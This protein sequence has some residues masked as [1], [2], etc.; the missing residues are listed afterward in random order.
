MKPKMP[1]FR[2]A[3]ACAAACMVFSVPAS[4]AFDFGIS[5]QDGVWAA[6]GF[7][8]KW[9]GENWRMPTRASAGT[10]I[11]GNTAYFT[12]STSVI[13][14]DGASS[15]AYSFRFPYATPASPASVS[16]ANGTLAFNGFIS[17][18][19]ANRQFENMTLTAGA[20]AKLVNA[21][22]KNGVVLDHN[23]HLV[24]E[25][26]ATLTETATDQSGS[27]GRVGRSSESGVS[28]SLHIASGAKFT[29]GRHLLI[30]GSDSATSHPTGVVSVAGS[31]SL[32]DAQEIWLCYNNG[33][34]ASGGY[35]GL[36]VTDG[37]RVVSRSTFLM[38]TDYTT[39]DDIYRGVSE[40]LVSGEGSSLELMGALT[41]REYGTKRITVENGGRLSVAGRIRTY[42]DNDHLHALDVTVR[43]GGVLEFG[44]IMFSNH[45]ST[46]AYAGQ[47][48]CSFTVDGGTTRALASFTTATANGDGALHAVTVGENGWIFDTQNFDVIWKR[49]IN[50]GT[51]TFT[52]IGSGYFEFGYVPVFPGAIDVSEGMVGLAGSS[53]KFPGAIIVRSGAA[54]KKTVSFSSEQDATFTLEAGSTLQPYQ[55]S[56]SAAPTAIQAQS[57]AL[58]VT[59]TVTVRL[60]NAGTNT[61]TAGRHNVL[62]ILGDGAF[63]QSDLA[64][65][66]LAAGAPGRFLLSSDAKSIVLEIAGASVKVWTGAAGDGKFATGGNWLDGA[67]P[68]GGESIYFLAGGEIDNNLGALAVSSITFGPDIADIAVSGGGF[69][70]VGA[71]TNLSS[72]ASP[73]VNAPVRF[74]GAVTVK[75][76]ATGHDKRAQSHVVF[77]GGAYAG[78]GCGMTLP[79]AGSAAMFGHF[80]LDNAESSPFA[81]TVTGDNRAS[82]S[83][84]SS[85]VVPN[86]SNFEELY[87][88]RGA[89]VTAGVLRL[90]SSSAR[91]DRFS[92]QNWGEVVITGEVILTGSNNKISGY[93]DGVTG[94]VFKIE[95][96]V[97]SM[98]DNRMF[99]A[100]SPGNDT[101]A[102]EGTFF[103]GQGGLTFGDSCLKAVYSI[104][105]NNANSRQTIRPWHGFFAIERGA[106]GRTAAGEL[107]FMRN[108]TFCTDDESGAPGRIIVNGRLRGENTPAMTVS[109]SGV[110]ELN[111]SANNS[112]QPSVAVVDTATLKFGAADV[113]LTTGAVTFRTGTTLQLPAAGSGAVALGGSLS[114]DD[115]EGSDCVH[116]KLGEGTEAVGAGTYAL[117][118]ASAGAAT[119]E[120]F[121]LANPTAGGAAWRIG[122][123]AD[124]TAVL[125]VGDPAPDAAT[126]CVWT[127]AAGDGLFSTAANWAGGRRPQDVGATAVIR[128]DSAGGEIVN[129]VD[130]LSAASIAFGK[131][132]K[133]TA[134]SGKPV[135]GVATV[136]NKS[137][138]VVP[139]IACAL[140]FA[141]TYNV[142]F[143]SQTVNFSGGA[144]ATYP[145]PDVTGR[146]LASHTLLGDITFTE[147][148]TIPNQSSGKP[149][150]IASGANVRGKTL[151]AASY[152]NSNYH[153]RVE[154][155]GTGEFDTIAVG[156]KLVFLVLGRLVATGDVTLGGNADG[157]DFGYYNANSTGTVEAHGIYKN[158]TGVGKIYHYIQNMK[159]GAGGFGMYRKDYS[160]VFQKD[161]RLTATDDLAIHQPVSGDGPKDGDWGLNLNGKT[162]TIDTAGHT[163]TFDSWVS[164]T[165]AKI[166]KEGE[167]E[168]IMQSRKKQHTGGTIVNGGTLTVNHADGLSSG[169]VTVNNDA[170]LAIRSGCKSGTG[171][172]TLNGTSRLFLPDSAAGTATVGGA[173][174]LNA[175]TSLVVTNLSASV[176]PLAVKSISGSCVSLV[177]DGDAPLADGAYTVLSLSSGSL[178]AAVPQMFALAGTAVAGRN[179]SL[180]VSGGDLVLTVDGAGAP[181]MQVCVWTG[182][183]GDSNFSTAANWAGGVKPQAGDG[184]ALFFPDA[185]GALVNDIPGLTPATITFGAGIG[186]LSISG[187]TFAGVQSMENKS[188]AVTPVMNA[189]VEFSGNI[190]FSTTATINSSTDYSISGATI[191]FAG[192]ASGLKIAGGSKQ[193]VL[194]GVFER[195]DPSSGFASSSGDANRVAIL[196]GSTVTATAADCGNT[197]ELYIQPE[198]TLIVS[199]KTISA[200][201]R[202]WCWNMGK[203]VVLD[204][205]SFTYNGTQY[206]GYTGNAVSYG[207]SGQNLGSFWAKTIILDGTGA[208]CMYFCNDGSSA[209]YKGTAYDVYVGEG[210]MQFGASSKGTYGTQVNCVAR[211]HPWGSDFTIMAKPNGDY[212]S[213]AGDYFTN[214][215]TEFVTTDADGVTPRTITMDGIYTQNGSNAGRL[216][217]SG[218]GTYVQNGGSLAGKQKRT[219]AL[220]VKDTATLK[221]GNA[222]ALIGTGPVTMA[223]GT[224]LAVPVVAPGVDPV[225]LGSSFSVSGEG[226][227]KLVVG[228]G[229]ELAPGDYGLFAVSGG[230]AAGDA[231][232]FALQ[233][234]TAGD[235]E[236]Y[237]RN[238][239][240]L[241]LSVG[242]VK[243]V[244]TWT[245]AGDGVHFD[246]AGNWSP[247]FVPASGSDL[248]FPAVSGSLVNDLSGF[249]AKTMT[250]GAGSADTTISG[251]AISGVLAITNLSPSANIV[252]ANPV[253]YAP[254]AKME[255]WQAGGYHN[256]GVAFDEKGYVVFEGGVTGDELVNNTSGACNVFAGRWTRTSAAAY[257]YAKSQN[258]DYRQTIYPGSSLTVGSADYT[259]EL[260]IGEGGAFTAATI[261]VA[262]ASDQRFAVRNYGEYVVK[263]CLTVNGSTTKDVY[264]GYNQGNDVWK[265]EKVKLDQTSGYTPYFACFNAA[266]QGTFFIGSGG[267]EFGTG[268]SR[269]GIGKNAA[270]DSQTIRPWYSDFTIT[271]GVNNSPGDVYGFRDV[272]FNTDDESGVGRTITLDAVMLFNHTPTCT[273]SGSGTFLVNSTQHNTA[274]PP[275]TVKDSATLK[276]G[277][278]DAALSTASHTFHAGTTLA[279]PLVTAESGSIPV[280]LGSG[281]ALP[282]DGQVKLVIGDGSEIPAGHYRVLTVTDG[283]LPDG[284]AEKLALQNPTAG[285]AVLYSNESRTLRLAVGVAPDT[286][287]AKVW[288]GAAGDGKFSTAGN[289]LGGAMPSAGDDIFIDAASAGAIDNDMGELALNSITFKAT[290]APVTITGGAITGLAAITNLSTAANAVFEAPVAYAAGKTMELYQT[291]KY[292]S[293]TVSTM[294]AKGYVVFAG[295]VTGEELINNPSGIANIF[296]GRWTRT[297]AAD[298]LHAQANP[299]G[300][301]DFRQVVYP[302][303]SLTVGSAGYT[304]ELYIGEGGAFTAATVTVSLAADQRFSFHNLGE[305]VVTECLTVNGSTSKDV[306]TGYLAGN[307]VWKFEKVKLD[308]TSGWTPYFGCTQGASQGTFFI[309]SGGIEFGTGSSR[310]GIGKNAAGDSQ[311]IRPWY[312]DF[313][314]THGVNNSPGDVYGFR[315]VVF[316][317]DD[318]S[319]VGRTITLDAVMLFNYT[320]TC[321]IS[322]SGTF[323]VNSTQQNTAQPPVAV[324]DSATLKF[325]S[326]A[327]ALSTAAHTFHAGTTLAVPQVATDATPVSL[328][329]SFAVAGEGKVKVAIGDGSALADGDYPVAVVT[330][331][332]DSK[333]YA[334]LELANETRGP[335]EFYSIDGK[336]LR[337]AVGENAYS[338]PCVWTGAAG[339]GKFSTRGNWIAGKVPANGASI[340]F[341]SPVSDFACND[342]GDLEI[343]SI[344]FAA[345]SA[346][347]GVDSA[348]G[349]KFTGLLAVTNASTAFQ[350]VYPQTVFAGEYRAV[351][352][353]QVRF[354]GGVT[355]TCPANGI[356]TSS[357][358]DI[359][360]TMYG[361]FTFTEDWVVTDIG[362]YDKPWILAGAGTEVRGKALTGTQTSRQRILSVNEGASAYFTV[363][364]NGWSIGDIDVNGYVEVEGE[365]VVKTYS[366]DSGWSNFGRSGNK[367]TVKAERFVKIANSYVKSNIPVI[368]VGKGG[369]GCIVQDWRWQF[370]VNTTVKAGDDFE[371]L[372]VLNESD[373]GIRMSKNITLTIDVPE[374]KTVRLGCGV[375]S[376][377]GGAIKKTGAGTLVMTDTAGGTGGYKKTYAGGTAVAEGVVRFEAGSF[378]TGAV[379][380]KDGATLSLPVPGEAAVPGAVTAEGGATL[381]FLL[382]TSG[383]AVLKTS[384]LTVSG[385]TEGKTVAVKFAEGSSLTPGRAYTLT[386]GANL[387]PAADANALFSCPDGGDGRLSIDANGELVYTAPEYFFIRIAT[388]TV[389]VPAAWVAANGPEGCSDIAEI[390]ANGMPVWQNYCLGLDPADPASLV[391]CEAAVSQP[392]DGSGRF[393]IVAKNMN[394]PEED[395]GATVTAYLDKSL[396]GVNWS[397]DGEPETVSGTPRTVTFLRSLDA[398]ETR[399]FFRIRVVVQ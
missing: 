280:V 344:T 113:T 153:L 263:E 166:V 106:A 228:D 83:D 102:S 131:G 200:N 199:N 52:K 219:A 198:A 161:S 196:S 202:A 155:G 33:S 107:Y 31:G 241:R 176:K 250:F 342:I 64:K 323:L 284:Y 56:A 62:T 5:G 251:N 379:T 237:V 170:T 287:G 156:G 292:H 85:L 277:S 158:V 399:C 139:E 179:A 147:N 396:D 95:K 253:E 298:Y 316:N 304:K 193:N 328:G 388:G 274:Q 269:L 24:L 340:V 398:L 229:A 244:C 370:D 397:P 191:D 88:G 374:G 281:I 252:F 105:A 48:Y 296:A 249:A 260:Y 126:D 255:I 356:R 30:G 190:Q 319:G 299:S 69:T 386:S 142:E 346:S 53:A 210:G 148:W 177:V 312:S 35:G 55:S 321:T 141:G 61:A 362:N 339:D 309:G 285:A 146:S 58:P 393:A 197:F 12:N 49:T 345:G 72:S 389:K 194:K 264:T 291:A 232:A 57:F 293:A 211:F 187:E 324:K 213:Y 336:T 337:V 372:G 384:G 322:G 303:S 369:L 270:G 144:T 98:S 165:A 109:G 335:V 265:F 353:G 338:G 135:S 110:F 283:A 273:I 186:Q 221:F 307:D 247:A 25:N 387:D 266:S 225:A 9:T 357:S 227:V 27:K 180:S 278:V 290:T 201:Q 390:C 89:A 224:T 349:F 84:G 354:P 91:V 174:A 157:R 282:E 151:A 243:Q 60:G 254:G 38:G 145:D 385:G 311:T 149:F 76:N 234:A 37:A 132:V 118:T 112:A 108:V 125:Y 218:S 4:G 189:R 306:Y 67:A 275:V 205:Y 42:A 206:L 367:G 40:V 330:G 359:A 258:G 87:I 257:A 262:L 22:A 121:R 377:T 175:G 203:F 230:V 261:T 358:D 23:S 332:I 226:K 65:F 314:I 364:T 347:M 318:E 124:G 212:S 19:G 39:P 305:Y 21:N 361:K 313:T 395:F 11:D 310:L 331:A 195:N 82:L 182:E 217:I 136:V 391:L 394:V 168:M 320:P 371:F 368:V 59:G 162:F 256:S 10:F 103:I 288:S 47:G 8:G 373:W 140:A 134:I 327:A 94:S 150:V 172:V 120:K 365:V 326:V 167:G 36:F 114:V 245:G 178:D 71:V 317:T 188:S 360:R 81:S 152:Q 3:A 63:T 29:T 2:V 104:G 86:A 68:S 286:H 333:A 294:D 16:L 45:D 111:T 363:M 173:L 154:E 378:G 223:A 215:D 325:G 348:D 97:Q 214:G 242:G 15:V 366:G 17:G 382:K 164:A 375:T 117:F 50:F 133:P 185:S 18:D 383:N 28:N 34:S 246:N 295:G 352:S 73:V 350:V 381:E 240:E 122:C 160:I 6:P 79:S 380:V 96:I 272:V 41:M 77:G 101:S 209:T 80:V 308:Q 169:A 238:G 78:A 231:A 329:S 130:N 51:G 129:D 268:S 100:Q 239:T 184:K 276:F 119:I 248:V 315:D 54:F 7:A 70:G 236:L 75:Q 343:K 159:V 279:V 32:L 204:K 216:T 208:Q 233:N 207:F 93:S 90:S 115:A 14:L 392:G 137:G 259:K 301:G 351:L 302:G 1:V 181:A 92:Y 13:D 192:G 355:A 163:V 127:G 220:E 341:D 297:S 183:G 300:G 235:E 138:S 66:V 143:D 222:A 26:G 376:D 99:L 267:I 46:R 334:S 43:N 20:G 74:A 289:W 123:L 271:H 171:A 44:N 116:L 128:F